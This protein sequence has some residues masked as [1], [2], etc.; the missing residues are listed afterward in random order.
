MNAPL[1][2]LTAPRIVEL[3][4]VIDRRSDQSALTFALETGKLIIQGL[5]GGNLTAWRTRGQHDRSFRQLSRL[6]RVSASALYRSVAIY[7]LSCRM[8]IVQWGLPMSQIRAV[9]GLSPANQQRLLEQ[10]KRECWTVREMEQACTEVRQRGRTRTLGRPPSPALLKGIN[11]LNRA[12]RTANQAPINARSLTPQQR[13]Q[14]LEGL[15]EQLRQLSAIRHR[16][17]SIIA[18]AEARAATGGT[19]PKQTR[20]SA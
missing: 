5:Y 2:T 7:E 12:I 14:A 17:A 18:R 6:T 13:Q 10:A 11:K 20:P 19:A 15:D 16:L 8:D 4:M 1:N 9:I 3:A